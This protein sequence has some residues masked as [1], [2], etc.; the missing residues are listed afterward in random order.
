[1]HGNMIL[2]SLLTPIKIN[3]SYVEL[4]FKIIYHGY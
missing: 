1:M 2:N 3:L 4:F